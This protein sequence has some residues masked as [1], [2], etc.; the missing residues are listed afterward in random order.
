MGIVTARIAVL[1]DHYH[2][3]LREIADLTDRQIKDIYFHARTKEGTIDLPMTFLPP[4]E[5]IPTLE[6][7]MRDLNFLLSN[8]A[9]SPENY[10]ECVAAAQEKFNAVQ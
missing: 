4:E 5:E 10:A 2:L 7:T 1:V 9:I 6:T 8:K 3:S